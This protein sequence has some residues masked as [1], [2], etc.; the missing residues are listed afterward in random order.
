MH[1]FLFSNVNARARDGAQV[2]VD[3]FAGK[4]HSTSFLKPA[5]AAGAHFRFYKSLQQAVVSRQAA[6]SAVYSV[7][8]RRLLLV[9]A[10]SE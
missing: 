1:A 8:A 10:T 3:D 7:D 2:M 9:M 5:A 6:H 4:V